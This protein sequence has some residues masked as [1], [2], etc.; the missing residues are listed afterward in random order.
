MLKTLIQQYPLVSIDS[1]V[2]DRQHTLNQ[3]QSVGDELGR[4]VYLWSLLQ[5]GFQAI[6]TIGSSVGHDPVADVI[7]SITSLTATS[8]GL[9]VFE[10]LFG[11]IKAVSPLQQECCYQ[12]ISQLFTRLNQSKRRCLVVLI[13]SRSD[14]IPAFLSQIITKYKLPLPTNFELATLL[15][16]YGIDLTQSPQIGRASCR[17]RV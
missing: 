15:L 1:T 9:Y 2:I 8:E 4:S 3:I 7:D 11:L 14:S 5:S 17:E 16:E 6:S 12:A 13:E 10:N